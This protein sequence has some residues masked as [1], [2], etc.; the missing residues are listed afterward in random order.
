MIQKYLLIVIWGLT[1]MGIKGQSVLSFYNFPDS[2]IQNNSHDDINQGLS[3]SGYYQLGLEWEDKDH[4][5]SSTGK[6]GDAST[7]EPENSLTQITRLAKTARVV[8]INEGHDL[9]NTRYF[10]LKVLQALKLLGF[11]SYGAETFG[12]TDKD[13]QKRKYPVDSTGY[14]TKEPV[15]GEVVREAIKMGYQLFPYEDSVHYR[16][17]KIKLDTLGSFMVIY[18]E[19]HDTAR[20]I[21]KP[22]GEQTYYT[23]KA[24]EYREINQAKNIINYLRTHPDAKAIIHVGYSHLCRD[25]YLMGFHLDTVLH[26]KMLTIDQVSLREHSDTAHEEPFYR[27]HDFNDYTSFTNS[28]GAPYIPGENS[29][30][31]VNIA[32][33]HPRTKFINGRP[34]WLYKMPGRKEY[35]TAAFGKMVP[36]SILIAFYKDEYKNAKQHAIPIDILE[37]TKNTNNPPLLLRAGSFTI[38]QLGP[39]GEEAKYDVEVK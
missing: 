8:L 35:A 4:S 29:D 15:Y 33:A 11:N 9:A 22:N 26:E 16:T 12:W 25:G 7:W 6:P 13:L 2:I 14:Y 34:D 38:V 1:T 28:T 32:V 18:P 23:G 37:L 27:Q 5:T 36:P 31:R 24:H 10:V 39:H 17:R 3:I 19:I 21:V 30:C 20:F